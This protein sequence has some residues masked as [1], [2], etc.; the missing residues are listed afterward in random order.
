MPKTRIYRN[1]K[2]KVLTFQDTN[3]YPK[4]LTTRLK[5]E[6]TEIKT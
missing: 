1:K 3:M 4:L 6:Y 2:H 5:L